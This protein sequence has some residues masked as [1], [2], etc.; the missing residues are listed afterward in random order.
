[1]WAWA[2]GNVMRFFVALVVL[3]GLG[4]GGYYSYQKWGGAAPP[5]RYKTAEVKQ[6]PITSTVSATGTIEPL[7][8]VLVGSQVSGTVMK[9]YA[10]FN[11]P[12]TAGFVLAELDQDRFKATLEQRTAAA[13]VAK[14]RVEEAGARLAEAALDRERIQGAFEREASSDF[15]LKQALNAEAAATAALHA[16]EAQFSATEADR[17]LAEIE[18][19]KTIIRS[20]IDGIVISRDVDAGQTVAASLSAPT[21][22]TIANDLS[23]MR[24]NAAVSETDIGRIQT[25]M[26]AEFRVDAY[27]ARRF[28][29]VVSQ[30]R[31]AETVVDNVV[32]YTTLIDVDNPDLALRP[33]M[34]A[35]ILFEVDRA[36]D[37]LQ[38]PNA[39]LR[40]NP[41]GESAAAVDWMRP[42]K[43]QARQSRVYVLRNDALTEVPVEMGLNDGAFTQIKAGEL[44]VGDPVVIEQ[45]TSG[46]A[47]NRPMQQRM[48]RMM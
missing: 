40:F 10:D 6:G 46:S 28:R 31:F 25:G 2:T 17:R 19:G 36:D 44:R 33:G 42:G 35:T 15:E 30:V 4:V 22:F 7:V 41:K 37:V 29:G 20:P 1:M 16:A 32:T 38:V 8:K 11:D 12:V 43:G 48:P 9:W 14:A 45:E 39:A 47:G 5:V 24:V 3:A 23:K 26:P 27:P 18:L 13:A 21:L 34:T